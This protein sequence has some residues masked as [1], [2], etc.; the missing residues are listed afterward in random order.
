MTDH[1]HMP[2]HLRPILTGVAASPRSRLTHHDLHS[3]GHW[4]TTGAF[5]VISVLLCVGLVAFTGVHWWGDTRGG[6]G[7]SSGKACVSAP[8]KKPEIMVTAPPNAPF[9]WRRPKV[10]LF[11]D[12]LT[13]RGFGP[14]GWASALAHTFMRKVRGARARGVCVCVRPEAHR[15]SVCAVA[16]GRAPPAQTLVD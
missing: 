11:G 8:K 6:S 5:K 4:Y 1:N 7:A 10:V 15:G 9:V 13:E 14:G 12:S 3:Q 16:A 2:N